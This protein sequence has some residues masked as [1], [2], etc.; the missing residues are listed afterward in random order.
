MKRAT[1]SLIAAIVLSATVVAP[2]GSQEYELIDIGTLG[3]NISVAYS[4][5]EGGIIA[6]AAQDASSALHPVLWIDHSILDMGPPPGF[7]SG[8]AVAANDSGQA[9]VVAEG[10]PQS[11]TGYLWEDYSW[12][13]L[14]VL[15]DREECIPEDID[16]SGRIVGSCL[17]LGSGNA[18]AFIW[19]SGEMTDLGTLSGAARAYGINDAGQVVGHCR[20]TQPGGNG[21]QRGFLWESGSMTELPPLRG[22]YNSKAYGVS[23]SGDVA[24]S[25]WYPTGP[26]SL[27]VD[28]ATVWTT[29]GDTLD[30]D[31]TPGPPVC[32]ANWRAP[33]SMT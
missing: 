17:T 23:E 4:I 19:E 6:G 1:A 9:V 16:S 20:A 25:S 8:E 3:G 24:G 12:T 10:S 31:Y 14:G 32:S 18:A 28:R 21:E 29:D 27:T 22:R 2:A 30:L 15:P 5:T 33:A 13:D 11:Y 7:Y 26:Y